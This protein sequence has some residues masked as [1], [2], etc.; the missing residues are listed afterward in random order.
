M[1]AVRIYI[2]ANSDKEH[3]L[4]TAIERLCA[5]IEQEYGCLSCQLYQ[6]TKEP[7]EFLLV[8]EWKSMESVKEHV[9]SRNIAVLTGAGVILSHEIRVSLD[10]SEAVR[11]LNK[12][13]MSR[14]YARKKDN[15]IER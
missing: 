14:L 10:R 12:E 2:T 1:I 13:Y 7:L 11:E 8:E 4:K 5:K 3:E 9:S 15:R 6:N